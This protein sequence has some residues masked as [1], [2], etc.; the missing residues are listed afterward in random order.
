[1]V[2]SVFLLKK[3]EYFVDTGVFVLL[4]PM[5]ACYL[6]WVVLILIFGGRFLGY[7]LVLFIITTMMLFFSAVYGS[8]C[9]GVFA[10]SPVVM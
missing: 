2:T 4:L 3:L 1:V 5:V 6:A 10:T 7:V 9:W 8:S